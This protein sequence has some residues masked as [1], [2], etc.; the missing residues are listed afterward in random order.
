MPAEMNR[1]AYTIGQKTTIV[2]YGLGPVELKY[3]NPSDD[4]R[5]KTASK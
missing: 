2:L 4:P 5:H 3:V 1:Y